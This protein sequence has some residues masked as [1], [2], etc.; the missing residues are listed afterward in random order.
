MKKVA[1]L[2][3]EFVKWIIWLLIVIFWNYGYPDA[4]PAKDVLFAA[5][6]SIIFIIFEKIKNIV[7]KI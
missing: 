7:N 1:Q 5:F 3:K 2:N 4:S 6:L